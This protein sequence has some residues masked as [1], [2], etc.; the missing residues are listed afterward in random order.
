MNLQPNNSHS[1]S[2]LQR[3]LERL[4]WDSKDYSHLELSL[5][6]LH[7][8]PATF[9]PNIPSNLIEVLSSDGDLIWDPFCG[10]GSVGVEAL[11]RNRTFIGTDINPIA[12]DITKAKLFLCKNLSQLINVCSALRQNFIFYSSELANLEDII[13]KKNNDELL[14]PNNLKELKEWYARDVF[15]NLFYIKKYIYNLNCSQDVKNF[16]NIIFLSVARFV[17]AQNKSWGHIADNVK[18]TDEQKKNK[19]HLNPFYFFIQQIDRLLSKITTAN[20]KF[21]TTASGDAYIASAA[22]FKPQSQVDLVITSPPYPWMCDYVTSQ[23]LAYL[24]SNYSTNDFL[25][26]RSNEAGPRSMRYK[27]DKAERY[28]SAIISCFNNIKSNIKNGGLLCMV[29]PGALD[30]NEERKTALSA[31]YD[32]LSDNFEK[33]CYIERFPDLY[34]RSSPF[35]TL[36]SEI[37]SVWRK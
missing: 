4:D 36:E 19:S 27:K 21:E 32:H 1:F 3:L 20:S 22:T 35:T 5:G 9:I 33:M 13:G 12:I 16:L 15:V 31:I 7:W 14:A 10:A 23:R 2:H 37:I 8:Y 6:F 30:K 17:C 11:K 29:L 18:P 24:W 28:T 26:L 34:R 25:E